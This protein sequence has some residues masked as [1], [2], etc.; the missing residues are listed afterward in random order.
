MR[1]GVFFP[2]ETK[3]ARLLF[4]NIMKEISNKLIQLEKHDIFEFIENKLASGVVT[5]TLKF[6]RVPLSQQISTYLKI[7]QQTKILLVFQMLQKS[8]EVSHKA[9]P[10]KV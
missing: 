9:M 3:E 8:V 6:R 5:K 2:G 4:P 10:L 7:F 1:N